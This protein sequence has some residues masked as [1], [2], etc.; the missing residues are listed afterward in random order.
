[1]TVS[2]A[3]S[4]PIILSGVCPLEDAETLLRMISENPDTTVD[5]GGCEDA[6]TAVVQ[7]LM[8]M[9][10]R[11]VGSPT[12]MPLNRFIAAAIRTA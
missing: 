4:G 5:W 12:F 7:V 9:K 10:P 6:H 11:V 1:M 2:M 8:A 3:G